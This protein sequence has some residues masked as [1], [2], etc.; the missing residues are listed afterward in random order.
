MPLFPVSTVLFPGGQLPLKIFE[1][2]YL[3]LVKA[4]LAQNST[5]GLCGIREGN[6]V[7]EPAIPYEIGTEVRILQWDMPQPG[8]FHIVVEGL[9]RF[10][11][12]RW[13][14]EGNGLLIAAIDAV[15]SEPACSVPDE[16][17]LC[18][19]VLRH[20]LNANNVPV[21]GGDYGNAVWVGYRL[22]ELLPFKM[23][24]KQNLLEMND[25]I[26]RLRLLDQFLRKQAR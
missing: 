17:R 1:Q 16:L 7:G 24:V 22:A 3:D 26:A 4:C 13:Q 11:A 19:E 15:S 21:S 8:I 2:R 14:A 9:D 25:P 10:V 12:R 6:E 5:F 20:I 23:R 18:T